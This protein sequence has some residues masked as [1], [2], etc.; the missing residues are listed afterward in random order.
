MNIFLI[1]YFLLL[2]FNVLYIICDKIDDNIFYV[3]DL[4]SHK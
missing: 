1:Y 3:V 2:N 4:N